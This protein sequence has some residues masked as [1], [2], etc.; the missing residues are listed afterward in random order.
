MSSLRF[1]VASLTHHW[2]INLAVALGV[3]AATAVLTGALLVGDSVRG[4]LTTLTLDRLGKID[5]ALIAD[6]FFRQ[7]LSVELAASPEFQEHYASAVPAIVFPS[8]TV[9][10]PGENETRR[11][12]GVLVVGC[13]ADFWRLGRDEVAPKKVP[14][15][16]Q[17]VLNEPLASEL[18]IS[19]ADVGKPGLSVTLRFPKLK[20][21]SGE[22]PLGRND[23]ESR[24]LPELEVVDVIPAESL[25]RFSLHPSQNL[26]HTA[27]VATAALQEALDQENKVNAIFVAGRDSMR[28]PDSKASDALARAL[29]PT[30]A[31]YGF[32]LKR[33]RRTFRPEV[34]APEE[35]IFDYY[36]FSTERMMLDRASETT[37]G[38]AFA[39][40]HAQ[41]VLTYLANAIEKVGP[42]AEEAD[43]RR[44][45]PYSTMT[46]IDSATK[47]GPLL[48]EKGEPIELADDEIVLTSWSA[49]DL[50]AT[51]G[52]EIA[53][54]FFEPERTH[55]DARERTEKFKLK[56]IV[57]LTEP[58]KPFGRRA[59]RVVP[60]LYKEQPTLL[61]DPDL[62]PEVP[63]VTD[64]ESIADWD[65]PFPFDYKRLKGQDDQYWNNHRTT[66]KAYISLA[67][68]QRIWGSRFGKLTSYR[69]PAREGLTEEALAKKFLDQAA[70]D[71]A[72]L[73]LAFQPIKRE[74]L[75]ASSGATPF[76]AL[77]LSL[78]FFIIA[79]ALLLVSL[80]FRL[81]IEQRASEVG[82]LLALGLRRS[83]AARLFV[84]EG[85][86][87]A[88]LGGLAGVAG[89]I[90][91]A[92][93]MLV[94]LRTIWLGAV[95]TPF[96]ALH[97]NPRSLAIGYVS[98]LIVSVLTIA[99]SV[100]QTRKVSQRQLLAGQAV[101]D[102]SFNPEPTATAWRSRFAVAV[103]SGLNLVVPLLLV[104]GALALAALATQFG[105]EAQAGAFM[106]SGAAVLAAAL[107]IISGRLR[108]AGT[109][110]GTQSGFALL[111]LA[112]RNAARNPGRSTLTMGLIAAASFLIVAV[113]AFRL[114]P[115]DEGAGGF[116]L[117]A[118]SGQP[119]YVNLNTE[120]GRKEMLA[121]GAPLLDGGQVFGLRLQP[122]DDA[123]CNNL[124]QAARPRVVGISPEFIK[125]F[126]DK[127]GQ[128]FAWAGSAATTTEEKQNP[129]RVLAR[130]DADPDSAV[131]VVIDKNTAMYSLKLYL[132]IGEKFSV[133]YEDGS[134]IEFRVAGL[135]ANSILQGSLLISEDDF[136]N[137]FPRVNGYRYFL[138]HSPAG[139]SD[140]VAQ[141]LEEKLSDQ[142]FD[143]TDT[144]RLL[145]DLLAVQNTYLS[146]FQ[147]LGGLG[148]LL[149]TFGL[150]AV[151]ARNVLE[152]RG[153]LA[154]LRA[155]GFR[156]RRLAGLVLLENL[157]LLLTGLVTGVFAA[158][159][160]VLPH[161]LF[162]GASIP[163]TPLALTLSLVLA[164]GGAS[165]LFST[166]ATLRAPLLSALRG[167]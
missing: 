118:E 92:W 102:R 163:V 40:D 162:G 4:S 120:S 20:Q 22:S 112:A 47:I 138:I 35:T 55:G 94:G 144:H 104:I 101:P 167:E 82:I 41:G 88:A 97:M 161:W 148:L 77:F 28:P 17:I 134:Q 59:G 80:L 93:L 71:G 87:V 31:D 2:R 81:G 76:D 37:A 26:P 62:T 85:A 130:N 69:I 10:R 83:K 6:R 119:I 53:V 153:E 131:P 49:E 99:W 137:H 24:A 1:I 32:S 13:G 5:E 105:G 64:Q 21:V 9:E 160:A 30:L 61:N 152:R 86:L 68:G 136:K 15:P 121:D 158:L 3:F 70:R 43:G 45:I 103:G 65:A 89:G 58:E 114:D 34:S 147:A 29:R 44:A 78:S 106:G 57:P 107:L 135:L 52:D 73:G 96:L 25:G 46:A 115:T 145:V 128:H 18:G 141:M 142:G 67:A 156:R 157:F 159:V 90:A 42:A 66:P 165:A 95:V 125:H 166:Q 79:A 109:R 75:R 111:G 11:T 23:N 122:G 14:V 74:S 38:Q 72:A 133:T 116:D 27:Y 8:G 39:A 154:L 110:R 146:T 91:Y 63:G 150:A 19:R 56:A 117:V 126:D 48:N 36:S 127:H 132:G 123:S 100:R 124:Y 50:A 51:P 7:E 139:E 149:G 16:G 113:S 140:K 151:Q 164:A 143:A 98:G 155:A 129:W 12:A 33:V 108:S 60:A 54:S 84:L